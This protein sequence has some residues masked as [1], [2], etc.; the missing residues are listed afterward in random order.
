MNSSNQPSQFYPRIIVGTTLTLAVLTA[1]AFAKEGVGAWIF[2]AF[3]GCAVVF[4]QWEY[5]QMAQAKGHQPFIFL[6]LATSATYLAALFFTA[7]YS[8][9][10]P[11]T[12]VVLWLSLLIFFLVTF[13][14]RPNPLVNVAL[15]LFGVGYLALPLGAILL[16][17]YFPFPQ[18][19]QDGRWWLV[20]LY[21]VTKMTDVGALM[22]GK[23]MGKH[24]LASRISPNKTI[25]G[26]LGGLSAA[27]LVSILFF[28]IAAHTSYPIAF[29]I[30]LAQSLYLGALIGIVAQLGDL[31]ESVLKRDAKVKHSS[32]L[33]GLGGVLDIVDS[34]VFTAPLLLFFMT[35][36]T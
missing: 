10:G 1:I 36:T 20:Y 17:A 7:R 9:L 26:A 35:W 25:E 13:F 15:T 12:E 8:G 6:G 2:A 19:T 34:L 29:H 11:L 27:I 24:P 3:I 33:P 23:L 5:Y 31:S 14:P 30:T 32:G 21:A 28:V 18:E 4:A 22:V 16:I